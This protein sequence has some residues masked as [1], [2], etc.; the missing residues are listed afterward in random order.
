MKKEP[1]RVWSILYNRT[2]RVLLY[3]GHEIGVKSYLLCRLNISSEEVRKLG[4]SISELFVIKM[5]LNNAAM[6]DKSFIRLLFKQR[7]KELL[8]C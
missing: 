2:D 1:F 4:Y 8:G 6:R 5:R 3:K 7:I